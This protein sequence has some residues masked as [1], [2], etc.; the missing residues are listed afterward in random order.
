MGMKNVI[1]LIAGV[2]M[3]GLTACGGGEG[4]DDEAEKKADL[5]K[6]VEKAILKECR[7]DA[8]TVDD[9]TMMKALCS[10]SAEKIRQKS[11]EDEE[12][13]E[14]A[15]KLADYYKKNPEQSM[16]SESDVPEGVS[17]DVQIVYEYFISQI[18]SCYM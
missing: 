12:F 17:D 11:E 7:E 6:Q 8:E 14:N 3:L 9:P 5:P 15:L 13:A 10:C 18:K 1:A 4:K 2:A 16:L